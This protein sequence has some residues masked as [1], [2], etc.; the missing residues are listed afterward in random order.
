MASKAITYVWKIPRP[1]I[2]EQARVLMATAYQIATKTDVSSWGS[3]THLAWFLGPSPA[4]WAFRVLT[5]V[6]RDPSLRC[7]ATD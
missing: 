6:I 3:F 4:S 5:G 7:R 1:V 2:D